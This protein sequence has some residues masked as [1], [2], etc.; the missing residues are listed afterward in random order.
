MKNSK[1][2]IKYL[3]TIPFLTLS[4]M[5]VNLPVSAI[6]KNT[7]KLLVA[8]QTTCS[9][10]NIQTGQLALRST[11]NGQSK[12]GLDNG[13]TVALLREGSN[14]W[15]Y[16]RVL[17]GPNSR[18]NGLEGWVNSNYLN[19]SGESSQNTSGACDVVGIQTGQLAL[20]FTP[21]GRSK[22]GLDNG[23]LVMPLRTGQNPWVYVRVVRGPNARVNGMEGWVN[24]NY[25]NCE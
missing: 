24:R 11:P 9:V 20:R 15:V 12:A 22:A 6:P 17:A 13:D 10:V 23:N 8:Q 3:V 19:C 25:L 1:N 21:D 7:Q 18:V 14:P 5:G 16:V 2:L 4:M